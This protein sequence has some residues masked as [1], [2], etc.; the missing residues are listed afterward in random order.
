MPELT[1]RRTP[2]PVPEPSAS[3]RQIADE[4]LRNIEQLAPETADIAPPEVA[5]PALARA[6]EQRAKEK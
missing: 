4:L 3:E 2:A 6:L 5:L 1:P